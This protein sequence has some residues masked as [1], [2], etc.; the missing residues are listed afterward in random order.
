MEWVENIGKVLGVIASIFA[1]FKYI[2]EWILTD[3]DEKH[4]VLSSM[5]SWLTKTS[6][7]A[8][9][10]LSIFVAGGSAWQVVQFGMSEDPLTRGAVLLLL[11]S[12]WNTVIYLWFAIMIPLATHAIRSREKLYSVDAQT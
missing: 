1:I 11:C 8:A 9:A 12:L 5:K 3:P 6:I 4:R 2:K 10:V 7:K